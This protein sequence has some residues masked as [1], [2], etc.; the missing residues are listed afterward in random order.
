MASKAYPHDPDFTYVKEGENVKAKCNHCGLMM[1]P[2]L[3]EDHRS[4]CP[5]NSSEEPVAPV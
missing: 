1:D 5:E 4:D 3:T 2:T